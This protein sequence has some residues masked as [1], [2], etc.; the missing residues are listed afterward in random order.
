MCRGTR[1]YEIP[2]TLPPDRSRARPPWLAAT[3]FGPCAG[4]VSTLHK[5]I[6][7][8]EPSIPARSP[9]GNWRSMT[10]RSVMTAALVKSSMPQ[11]VV[12]CLV[13]QYANIRAVEAEIRRCTSAAQSDRALDRKILRLLSMPKYPARARA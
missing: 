1:T 6:K 11:R 5:S 12:G 10:W 3:C 4:S 13:A 8:S 2:P 9:R 7:P